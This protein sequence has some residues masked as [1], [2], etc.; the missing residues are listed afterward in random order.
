MTNEEYLKN[1][2]MR[3]Y[4][5]TCLKIGIEVYVENILAVFR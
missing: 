4:N 3:K 2:F 1:G 5:G